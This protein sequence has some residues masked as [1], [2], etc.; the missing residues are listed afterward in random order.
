M[1][2]SR[3]SAEEAVGSKE[4]TCE[5]CSYKD[6]VGILALVPGNPSEGIGESGDQG[7][8]DQQDGEESSGE[9]TE[10]TPQASDSLG[11]VAS[12]MAGGVLIGAATAILHRQ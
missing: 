5:V 8:S 3:D 4:C 1:D 10:A 12:L 9:E 7:S 11:V 2:G 6:V